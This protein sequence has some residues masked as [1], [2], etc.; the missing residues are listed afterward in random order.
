MTPTGGLEDQG[1]ANSLERSTSGLASVTI[2]SDD[3]Q[4]TQSNEDGEFTLEG[5]SPGIHTLTPSKEGYAFS[6]PSIEVDL[7]ADDLTDIEIMGIPGPR[8]FGGIF[9]L[10][11]P[12]IRPD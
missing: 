2:S 10:H 3:G 12:L 5:L 1:L 8:G 4:A 6:P 9:S 7:S 11:L